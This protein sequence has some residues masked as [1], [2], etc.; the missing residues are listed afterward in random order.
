MRYVPRSV[1]IS[2]N[3]VT[4]HRQLSL[5]YFQPQGPKSQWPRN[6][7]DHPQ[8]ACLE[9]PWNC[10][11]IPG[12]SRKSKQYVVLFFSVS[13]PWQRQTLGKT[14]KT[15]RDLRLEVSLCPSLF[16]LLEFQWVA[17]SLE[18]CACCIHGVD[19][20]LGNLAAK[21]RFAGEIFLG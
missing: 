3:A 7:L 5:M 15:L 20:F 11:T 6:S 14:A 17:G 13:S 19:L 8:Q 4:P 10:L 18:L 9:H 12:K 16:R 2:V 1:L 21:K